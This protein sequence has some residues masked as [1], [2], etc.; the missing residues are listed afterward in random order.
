MKRNKYLLLISSLGVALLLVVAAVDE[1]FRREW[2]RIQFVGRTPEGP[3]PVGL[4]QIVNPSLGISDRCVSCHVSMA[5]GEQAIEGSRVFLPHPQVFHDPAEFGCTICHG[6]QGQATEKADAHGDVHF[7]PEPMLP[8]RF[9]YAGCGSCHAP[10]GVPAGPAFRRAQGVFQ[11]LDCLVCH[12]VDGRGG[13]LRPGGGGL[14]GPDLSRAGSDGYDPAWYAKHLEQARRAETGPWATAFA[15]VSDEDLLQLKVYL[16][17]R[18]GA[19][20]LL[21]AKSVFL[22]AGCLGCHRVS[23]VGGDEG[24]ELT[25]FGLRDPA[26]LSF[27]QVPGG[28]T[29]ENWIV[30]H[31][32]SPA[33][34]VAAS[35]MPPVGLPVAELDLLTMYTL[36]LRR[37]ELPESFLP[38]DRLG[39]TRF[40]GRE[41]L[42]EGESIFLAFCSGCHGEVG[43]GR[44]VSGTTWFPAIANPD[45]HRLVSDQFLIDA[46]TRGRAGRRMPA[47]GEMVGGLRPDEI[48]R[49]VDYLRD[50]SRTAPPPEESRPRRWVEAD[51]E[52]GGRLY[53]ATCRGC[54]GVRGEGGEGPALANPAFLNSATDT[55]LVETVSAGRRNTAMP[56]F[57]RASTAYPTLS[58][59]EIQAVVAFVRTWE[60]NR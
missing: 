55:F 24:P 9:S 47:W 10:L 39:V 6:G 44:R 3:I 57:S 1:N 58:R 50:L 16:G 31:F 42:Q 25:Q 18:V 46:V 52:W 29:L 30:E 12:R 37:R 38:R 59:D 60:N 8:A 23:G 5:P 34:V 28:R 54:H 53:A 51:V 27:A 41:Y 43:Q 17:T 11:R 4:R 49:V 22:G 19:G 40:D 35:Q 2:R 36:S 20:L 48:Q 26:Q 15:P 56:A 13:A 21:E 7:W 45:L 14:E 33:A 32:R